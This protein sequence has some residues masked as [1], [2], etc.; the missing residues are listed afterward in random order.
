MGLEPFKSHR[1]ALDFPR[2]TDVGCGALPRRR[3]PSTNDWRCVLRTKRRPAVPSRRGEAEVVRDGG[4]PPL[5][6][7]ERAVSVPVWSWTRRTYESRQ[8]PRRPSQ[9]TGTF[10]GGL[11]SGRVLTPPGDRPR[12]TSPRRVLRHYPTPTTLP[13]PGDGHV[14]RL[15]FPQGHV[16]FRP[17]PCF[18]G[19]LP[20][21]P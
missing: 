9:D 14:P 13:P 19:P 16:Q 18:S 8:N 17:S 2:V 3:R 7:T 12:V 15:P 21:P 4:T 5:P 6:Y 10:R 1:G 20:P 11:V